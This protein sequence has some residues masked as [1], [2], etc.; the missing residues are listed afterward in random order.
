MVQKS[1][2]DF[3]KH[4]QKYTAELTERVKRATQATKEYGFVRKPE[5]HINM[6]CCL[7]TMVK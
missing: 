1:F 6:E 7:T 4:M 2:W 5:L 3:Q